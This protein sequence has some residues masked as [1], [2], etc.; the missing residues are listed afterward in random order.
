MT[1]CSLRVV[2]ILKIELKKYHFF[3]CVRFSFIKKIA[4][5]KRRTEKIDLYLI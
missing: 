5:T 1:W 3:I 2:F 4:L